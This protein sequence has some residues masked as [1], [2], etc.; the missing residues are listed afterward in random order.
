MHPHNRGDAALVAELGDLLDVFVCD[1]RR[2]DQKGRVRLADLVLFVDIRAPPLCLLRNEL[3]T[4]VFWQEIDHGRCS[5]KANVARARLGL[6]GRREDHLKV[7]ANFV[8]LV[9]RDY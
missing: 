2:Y 4:V 8:G 3:E 6:L 7:I 1:G 5:R 9:C